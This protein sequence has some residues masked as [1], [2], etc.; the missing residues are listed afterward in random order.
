MPLAQA[1]S[2][3]FFVTLLPKTSIMTFTSSHLEVV[4]ESYVQGFVSQTSV[5]GPPHSTEH[6]PSMTSHSTLG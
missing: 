4:G 2:G 5:F 3:G 6:A 1:E